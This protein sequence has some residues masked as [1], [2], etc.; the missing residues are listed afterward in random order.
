MR[1]TFNL[2]SCFLITFLLFLSIG[3]ALPPEGSITIKGRVMDEMQKEPIPGV[4]VKVK[5]STLGT[6]TDF[7]GNFKLVVPSKNSVLVVSFI[8]YVTQEIVVGNQRTININL[9]ENAQKLDEVVV[10]AY[11]SQDKGLVTSAISSIDNKELIKS[12]VAS[13][14]NI[15]AGILPG[16]SSVQTTGQP[17]NDAADIYVRGVGTL[18]DAMSKPL[19]MID[20]VEREFSQI[21]PNEIESIS[22]LKDASSTAVFGVRGANGVILVT[23]RRGK[24]G[25]AK[26]SVSTSLG[27]QQPISLVEQ[28]GSYEYARFWNIKKKQD[29]ITDEKLYFTPEQVE[30][31]RTGSDPLMY[32]N[33]KWMDYVFHNVF[34]Q[35]K[36]NVNISGGS[37]NVKYFISVGY[38]YQNGILKDLPGQNYNSNYRYDRYN[39]RANIDAKLTKTTNMKLNIGGNLGKTQEPRVIEDVDNPWVVTQIWSHP[40]S[41]PGFINGVRTLIPK[42]FIPVSDTMR[43]GMFTFYGQGYKQNY[44]TTLNLDVDITQKLDVLTKGLSAS[45]KGAYDNNFNLSKTRKGG[46]VESQIIYYQSYFDTNGTMPQTDPD[47]DKTYIFVPNGS[48]TP[49]SYEESQ[50]RGQKWYIEGRINYDRTFGDHKVSGLLLYNQS[51]EYY[52]KK[53][54]GTDAPYQFIP[55]GY[56]G[57]V[58][59]A[60]Y[61]YQSKYLFDV[62]VGYNGS[63]NFAPGRT[64]F[65]VFPAFSAGWIAS[66]EKFMENQNIIDFLKF[67]V[68]WGRVGNDKGVNNRFM[69]MPA[70]WQS[71]GSYSFGVSNPASQP[72]F[73]MSQMGNPEVTWETADKQ[74]YGID[75]HFLN[76]RLSFTFDYFTE[77]RKGILI[78][79]QSTPSIIA[80][81]LP[82]LNIGKVNNHG[83]EIALGWKD[84][85]GK[86][87]NYHA[88]ATVSFARNKIIFKDEVPKLYDYMNETGGST[89]RHTGSY[90]YIRL[91]QYSDFTKDANG[92]LIL[93]PK[94]PQPYQRVYPGDAM[95]QDLN[96]DNIVDENDKCITGYPNRPEYTFGLNMGFNWKGINLSMQW[97]GATNVNKEYEVDYRIPFTN[98]SQRGLLT[99]FYDGCWTPE[100]QLEAKYP[101]ASET[102]ESWNSELSTLWIK[103]SSYLRLKSINIGYTISGKEFLRKIGINSLSITFS[104]YNLL[105]FT[106]LKYIDPEGL[107]T[108]SGAYPLIKIYSFGLNLNF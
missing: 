65:G 51:R 89:K 54:N 60:T 50:D 23:T 108:N 106:P 21:D 103:D 87:F 17:G 88:D 19:I 18:D 22:I 61:A 26:I 105:T 98:A 66:A 83:Y 92:E 93:D 84:K 14:T 100:N 9:K 52:P 101:R 99:Y 45:I 7:N 15:L 67:R 29:G 107:T 76:N 72:A 31:Y 73:A 68:S 95:Y 91:Y 104:G 28:T 102:S 40:F 82:D 30:A 39:Y 37:E 2:R 24:Q 70:V 13:I 36:N 69:Y 56:V 71:S 79:P 85:I 41:G 32:P 25:K 38:L 75:T 11:G 20:G 12:P 48:D 86:D 3:Y 57:L 42:G 55:R 16:V 49:L 1:N 10:I 46:S 97:T 35:S 94:L 8:G 5:G 64:R 81:S 33:M 90:K 77:R 74:N 44:K 27:L 53:A 78:S 59:R 58:G 4:N 63:E 43:D 34:L 62:N 96:G 47:Y 80:T 6:I